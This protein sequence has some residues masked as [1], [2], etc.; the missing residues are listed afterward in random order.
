[1][2]LPNNTVFSAPPDD[3]FNFAKAIEDFKTG[4]LNKRFPIT[5]VSATP[6]ILR[7]LDLSVEKG[8]SWFAAFGVQS[9]G[10]SEIQLHSP[11]T[12]IDDSAKVKPDS[13]KKQKK[14]K[15]GISGW[16][17]SVKS[18]TGRLVESENERRARHPGKGNEPFR[19]DE[20]VTG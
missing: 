16:S 2:I 6:P 1:M 11:F 17:E 19:E 5:V 8:K 20:N 12:I 18:G 15:S 9:P 4:K 3:Q 10:A 14:S 13:E 7:K